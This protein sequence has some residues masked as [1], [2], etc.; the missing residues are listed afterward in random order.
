MVNLHPTKG[1]DP[2]ALFA[3]VFSDAVTMLTDR[4]SMSVVLRALPERVPAGTVLALLSDHVRKEKQRLGRG[5]Q[6]Q[7][8][9]LPVWA[10]SLELGSK[11]PGSTTDA[12]GRDVTNT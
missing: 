11:V 10:G 12:A 7:R 6:K 4:A 5:N 2:P 8:V 1:V 9:K 3:T